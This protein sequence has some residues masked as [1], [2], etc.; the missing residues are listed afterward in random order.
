MTDRS[1]HDLYMSRA[2]T[3]AARGLGHVKTNPMVGSVIVYDG[4][5]ISEGY[6]EA[7]G[8]LHA[9]R[10]AILNVSEYDRKLL[11]KSTIYVTLEPCNH[12]GK[13]PPCTDIILESGIPRV[14]ICQTDPNPKMSGRSVT[15][16]RDHGVEVITGVMEAAGRELNR[17]FLTQQKYRR[18]YVILKYA[19]SKDGY[20]G[21][22][23]KSVWI[24][25][26]YSKAQVHKWRTEID[27]IMVGTQTAVTD[28]PK[29]TT[30]L[31]PGRTPLRVVIDRQG[32]IPTSHQLLS[33]EH[34]TIVYTTQAAYTTL[35][36]EK[37][38]IRI[39]EN[40][41]AQLDYI[42]RD[43]Y[44]RSVGRLMIEGGK[45]LLTSMIEQGYWDEARLIR[46]DN[47]LNKGIKAPVI[48]GQIQEEYQLT[49][50]NALIINRLD[51]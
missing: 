1:A 31:W 50:N 47:N 5:I 39:P 4:R 26:E 15:L 6:H 32:R 41:E 16:L 44:Q 35:S 24:S 12:H 18:P 25:N 36:Q 40:P 9:E 48:T 3:L 38:V 10:N 34:P 42:L 33:D 13:T 22:K 20:M 30:R 43:L 7:Y 2:L 51:P 19:M 17:A 28:D 27:A 14:V 46:S 11:P 49:D 21:Q 8:G 37:V 45:A 23:D 29:L